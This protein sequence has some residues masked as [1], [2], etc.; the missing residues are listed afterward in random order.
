MIAW[1]NRVGISQAT[2]TRSLGQF[3]Q[4]TVQA[5]SGVGGLVERLGKLDSGFLQTIQHA[6]DTGTALRQTIRWIADA[7]SETDRAARATAAFGQEGNQL[8]PMLRQGEAGFRAAAERAR[9]FGQVMGED[10]VRG[11]VAAHENL[12]ALAAFFSGG[13]SSALSGLIGVLDTVAGKLLALGQGIVRTLGLVASARAQLPNE[14]ARAAGTDVSALDAQIAQYK[15]DLNYAG[16]NKSAWTQKVKELKAQ[17]AEQMRIMDKLSAPEVDRLDYN[18]LTPTSAQFAESQRIM[19]HGGGGGGGGGRGGGGG[20]SKQ[21]AAVKRFYDYLAQRQQDALQAG[22][23]GEDLLIAKRDE[24]YLKA[25]KLADD[26]KASEEQRAQAYRLIWEDYEK[27]IAVVRADAAEKQTKAAEEALKEQQKPFTNFIEN[28]QRGFGDLFTSIIQDGKISGDAL[29]GIFKQAA[30]RLVGELISLQLTNAFSGLLGTASS[31][32]SSLSTILG[33]LGSTTAASSAGGGGGVW[34]QLLGGAGSVLGSGLSSVSSLLNGGSGTAALLS[35]GL[36]AAQSGGGGFKLNAISGGA[37]GLSAIRAVAPYLASTSYGSSLVS[38]LNGTSYGQGLLGVLGI[39]GS[40]AGSVAG[41]LYGGVGALSSLGGSAVPSAFAP[42]AGS[43]AGSSSGAGPLLAFQSQAASDASLAGTGT[44]SAGQTAGSLAGG[45]STLVSIIGSLYS[46]YSSVDSTIKVNKGFKRSVYGDSRA[47]QNFTAASYAGLGAAAGTGALAGA[48]IGGAGSGGNPIGAIVGAL[49]GAAIGAAAATIVNQEIAKVVGSSVHSG[50]GQGVTQQRLDRNVSNKIANGIIG[51]FLPH[52]YINQALFGGGDQALF[53]SAFSP[54]IEDIFDKIGAKMVTKASRGQFNVNRRLTV[55]GQGSSWF[56]QAQIAPLQDSRLQGLARLVSMLSGA[57]RGEGNARFDRM[58]AILFNSLAAGGYGTEQAARRTDLAVRGLAGGQ[59]FNAV[60]QGT[61]FGAGSDS[62]SFV[63]STQDLA[64]GRIFGGV[65]WK[66]LRAAFES[67]IEAG[68]I[69]R[70]DRKASRDAVQGALGGL[71]T[72]STS[73]VEFQSSLGSALS[74]NLEERVNKMFLRG[75]GGD[76]LTGAFA[77]IR[78]GFRK[79]LKTGD[80]GEFSSDV[81]GQ[82]AAASKAIRALNIDQ[83]KAAFDIGLQ[84]AVQLQVASGDIAGATATLNERLAPV[85]NVLKGYRQ[86]QSDV[87]TRTA[88][89]LA[90]SGFGGQ[91]AQLAALR[92]NTADAKAA[93]LNAFPLMGFFL[94]NGGSI[95]KATPAALGTLDPERA[96]PLLQAFSDARLSE[97]EAELSYARQL[98]DTWGQVRSVS[99]DFLDTLAVTTKGPSARRAI[100][101]RK[102]REFQ[103]AGYTAGGDPTKQLD[104]LS[105]GSDLL[106]LGQSIFAP[107]SLEWQSLTDLLDRVA[108]AYNKTAVEEEAKA[109]ERIKTAEA[110]VTAFRDIMTPV[111]GYLL[112]LQTNAVV[113]AIATLTKQFTGDNGVIRILSNIATQLGVPVSGNPTARIAGASAH[114]NGITI[115]I[116]ITAGTGSADEIV[117]HVEK[118]IRQNKGKI[119]DEIKRV[120]AA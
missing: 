55:Y 76:L 2:L 1:G 3:A 66:A 34:S 31:G 108:G 98:K 116:P 18:L 75:I 72:G 104:V 6:G 86:L 120:K 35:L 11:G 42:T 89:A 25:T 95:G 113:G 58:F 111:L 56:D 91:E 87:K 51:K 14:G 36:A 80:A 52:M 84:M 22:L 107:G 19:A 46:L 103:I 49:A 83:L 16:P 99:Q 64:F 65:D 59:Y 94:D 57:G 69:L 5:R 71:L 4:E 24:E 17:R 70:K 33:T 61:R 45:I 43:F 53:A 48:F 28:I 102:L 63:T 23:K 81:A 117:A 41:G 39:G 74:K 79:Y 105:R 13:F 32:G 93:L 85:V 12:S 110:N 37:L 38:S 77:G 50:I 101:D 88:F 114:G 97:L 115:N 40:A 30:A 96:L 60:R 54:D 15:N 20:A 112:T 21:E 10:V 92:S 119:V 78:R 68:K 44:T 26:A 109:Q 29:V 7:A 90:G 27:Q 47:T 62:L 100:Y 9:E 8:L 118:A 67:M 73:L 106:S 82:V